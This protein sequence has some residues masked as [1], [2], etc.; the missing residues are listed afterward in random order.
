MG[1]IGGNMLPMII[2]PFI[3]CDSNNSLVGE[4]VFIAALIIGVLVYVGANKGNQLPE[5]ALRMRYL[6]P[7]IYTVSIVMQFIGLRPIYNLDK[8]NLTKMNE[9]LAV[10]QAAKQSS[11]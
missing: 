8:K 5:V 4:R 11:V 7:A 6:V 9:E 10:R 3:I 2:L 1:S